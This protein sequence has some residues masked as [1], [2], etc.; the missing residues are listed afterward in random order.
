MLVSHI[1][2]IRGYL[3]WIKLLCKLAYKKIKQPNTYQKDISR[4]PQHISQEDVQ[5]T[6]TFNMSKTYQKEISRRPRYIFFFKIT[7]KEYVKVTL[8]FGSSKL[9]QKSGLKRRRFSVHWK[10]A[11]ESTPKWRWILIHRCYIE[12]IRPDNM[13]FTD[14]CSLTYWCNVDIKF[15]T[16]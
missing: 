8:S 14:I 1:S 16:N 15:T 9:H 3:W 6:F 5:T 10:D 2:H 12:K 11:K 7:L 4:Q 13:K